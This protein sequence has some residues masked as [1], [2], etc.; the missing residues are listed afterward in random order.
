MVVFHSFPLGGFEGG[1]AIWN[2]P[3]GTFAVASFFVISGYLISNSRSN[4]GTGVYLWKRILR[5]IPAYLFAYFLTAYVFSFIVGLVL[6]GWSLEAAGMYMLRGM[7]FFVF[8]PEEI[9]STLSSLPYPL[10]WNGSMWSV[11]IEALLYISTAVAFSLPRILKLKLVMAAMFLF[12][13]VLSLLIQLG[14]IVDP[15]PA[16]IL[17]TLSFFVP[18]YLAG[19]LLFLWKNKI[20]V[21]KSLVTAAVFLTLVTLSSPTLIGLSALPLGY[22]LLLAASTKTPKILTHLVKNDYSYGVYVLAFPIQQTLAA[23]GINEY[24]L[25]AFMGA[26]MATSLIFAFVSWRL[27]E[28][29]ALRLKGEFPRGSSKT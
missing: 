7:Q 8:G 15:T 21:S 1:A 10:S 12:F 18:F 2:M 27:V 29:P 26:S 25:L 11:R 22:L 17:T 13:S 19:S 3:L 20:A 6:G 24:G 16:G 28:S 4:S 14:V 5:I 9:G 23:L